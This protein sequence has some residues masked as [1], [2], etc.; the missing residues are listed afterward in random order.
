MKKTIIY[1]FMGA[2]VVTLLAL[3]SCSK[4]DSLPPIDGYSSSDAV[5]P[6]NLVAYFPLDGNAKDSKGTATATEVKV[7][8]TK[9][10][11]GQAYQGATGAYATLA[12]SAA[13]NSLSSYTVSMWYKLGAQPNA[14]SGPQGLFFLSGTQS[15]STSSYQPSNGTE[16]IFEIENHAK[17]G[18][19]SLEVHHGFT[20]LG[21]TDPN[22]YHSFTMTSYDTTSFKGWIHL[23]T[24]YD[25]SSSKYIIYTDGVAILNHSA[26]PAST[27][28][29]MF[30]NTTGTL[31]TTPQGNMSWASDVPKAITI[32]T[33][34]AGVYGV[35][36]TLGSNAC[37]LGQMDELRI[38]N[39]ALSAADVGALYQLG[40]AG[41]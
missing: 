11:R 41:R 6:T 30:Q 1:L 28:T 12:P 23:V 4:S 33:W 29:T 13:F 17:V 18:S 27:S 37:F 34:P 22:A 25:G 20:N 16:L 40:L 36:P 14:A 35:S 9:G 8:Y 5:A 21:P 26:F 15:N 38:Y 2:S 19:D 31:A 3:G 7:T 10:L 32:G 24:T 39:T